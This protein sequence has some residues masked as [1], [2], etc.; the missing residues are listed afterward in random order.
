ME[1]MVFLMPF[2][3]CILS[4]ERIEQLEKQRL[5][6]QEQKRRTDEETR[7]REQEAEE[8]LRRR[9]LGMFTDTRLGNMFS[10]Q[11][12]DTLLFSLL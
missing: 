4:I 5:E 12:T 8:E 2:F 9:K 3:F 10:K 1:L 6:E 11:D 7:L